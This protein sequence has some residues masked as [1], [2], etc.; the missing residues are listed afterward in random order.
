MQNAGNNGIKWKNETKSIMKRKIR[1]GMTHNKSMK[2]LFISAKIIP[3]MPSINRTGSIWNTYFNEFKSVV[4]T[5]ESL[6]VSL[7]VYTILHHLAR[8]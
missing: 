8:D 3:E 6:V 5:G 4:P 1:N 2:S 7:S